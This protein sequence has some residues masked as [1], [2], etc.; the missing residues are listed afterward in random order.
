MRQRTGNTTFL[1]A[2]LLKGSRILDVRLGR[3]QIDGLDAQRILVSMLKALSYDVLMLSGISFGGF[4]LVN[5]KKLARTTRKPVISVIR[6][7]PNNAAVR[8][9]LRKHFG[10]WR[11][12]WG[13]VKDAGPVYSCRPVAAEPKMYFE[14]KGASAAFARRVIASSSLISRLPEPVRVAGIMARGCG[15]HEVD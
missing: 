14:V 11:Q 2:A 9:A 3:I 8:A 7:K 12:R 4:N 15:F 13:I 10:D 6:D 5:L 1:V